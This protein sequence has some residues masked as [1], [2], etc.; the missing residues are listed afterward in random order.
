MYEAAHVPALTVLVDSVIDARDTSYG[1]RYSVQQLAFSILR[2]QAA[3]P[4]GELFTFAL[5][6]LQKLAKQDGQLSLPSLAKN[7]PR[8]VEEIIFDGIYSYAA[9]AGKRENYNLVL[10]LANSFGKRG[11]GSSSY[12]SSY[13]KPPGPKPREPR[14]GQPGSGWSRCRRAMNG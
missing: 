6:T 9:Q 7:M 12:S 5:D 8:G 4:G 2:H 1:T 11:T 3:E 13:G 10:S 14:S